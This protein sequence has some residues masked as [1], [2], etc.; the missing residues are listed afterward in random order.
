MK[1]DILISIAVLV[2]LGFG[3]YDTWFNDYYLSDDYKQ[4][5]K[6]RHWLL[7]KWYLSKTQLWIARII[8]ATLLIV[9][10]VNLFCLVT[11]KSGF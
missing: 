1:L 7:E 5:V 11:G 9:S 3:V 2:F 8:S 4:Y 10:I 6:K